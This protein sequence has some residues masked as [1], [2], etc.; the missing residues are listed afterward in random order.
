MTD[1]DE[2]IE[3][4]TAG[5][6]LPTIEVLTGRGFLTG[7][8]GS[9]KS[10]SC[11]VI[12]EELLDRGFDFLIVDTEGEYH[13]LTE[14]YELLHV[15]GDSFAEAQVGPED[16]PELASESLE[17]GIPLILDVSG[18]D[19]IEA[20]EALIEGVIREL[21]SLE[22]Q[23]RKPYLLIVEEMQEYLPQQ[24]N[25]DLSELLERVAKRGRKRGLGLLGVSQRPSAVDKDFITQ[26][27][28]MAWHKL[29]WKNDVDVARQVLGS[30]QASEI[31]SFNPGEAFLLTDWEDD[32]Q[33]IRFRKKRT[34]DAG[35]TP[36]LDQY[37]NRASHSVSTP[38]GPTVSSEA[39]SNAEELSTHSN[40]SPPGEDG[41]AITISM[42]E[43]E[44]TLGDVNDPDALRAA[45]AQTERRRQH[46]ERRLAQVTGSRVKH[47]ATASTE[48]SGQVSNQEPKTVQPPEKPADREGVAGALLEFGDL[49]VYLVRWSWYRLR[50]AVS[51]ERANR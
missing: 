34:F 45:L 15:G 48:T 36:G 50:L 47:H 21:F 51:R 14:E 9:G 13:G 42:G 17:D 1:T 41:E 32:I 46:I 25:D 39:Q 4:S 24:G 49:C 22:K 8:S 3:I 35:A 27:N 26:C 12:L 38:T 10:N 30:A 28:W 23:I 11:S 43:T 2:Y 44:T 16:A 33:R 29:T 40:G 5:V 7:K 31:E 6:T 20:S 37:E 19:D 18:Y